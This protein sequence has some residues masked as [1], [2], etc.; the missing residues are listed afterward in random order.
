MSKITL[1]TPRGTKDYGPEEMVV[2]EEV[3]NKIKRIFQRYGAVSI[4]TPVFE[5]REILMNKYGEDQKLVYDL[6]DQGGE[7][8]SLR[9]DLT[10]PFSRY[11]AQN[12]IKAIKKYQIGKVYRRDDP[13][14][15]AGRYR[16]FYQCDFDISGAEYCHMLPDAECLT[17]MATILRELEVGP[18]I[19]KINHRKLLD[20]I[21]S[22][23]N[24]KEEYFMT[25][26][27][28]IDKLDKVPW[29]VVKEEII[30]KGLSEEQADELGKY[31]QI[32][33]DPIK[34]I[35]DLTT[36]IINKEGAIT[37]DI[38][39]TNNKGIHALNELKLL[40]SYLESFMSKNVNTI[41]LDLSLARGLTY[42]TGIIFEATLVSCINIGSVGGGGRYDNLIGSLN[43]KESVPSV[44]FSI[45]VE[46]IFDIL[47]KKSKTSRIIH[48]DVLVC[49]IEKKDENFLQERIKIVSVLR[50]NDIAAEII[51][52]DRPNIKSQ[53]KYADTND[54]SFAIIIG[55]SEIEK[56]IV[57]IK[58]LNLK[59]EI[60][61]LNSDIVEVLKKI[62]NS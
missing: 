39:I 42:Y 18:F 52:K 17:I 24:I 41:V 12:N 14:M 60:E 29:Q 26:S 49:S 50:D 34:I 51:L 32:N 1:K 6:E 2:R 20:A 57:K 53:L 10:V 11:M 48:T 58:D 19:I 54:V 55:K 25:V 27:S 21:F 40:M 9:Y 56:G 5:L 31:V 37:N 22:L 28:S 59:T 62:M 47:Q 45:G 23:S 43:G 35:N 15:N 8:C 16:E 38:V 36:I 30:K 7:I 3:I 46:R 4:E 61:C 44:G 33:G 13:R